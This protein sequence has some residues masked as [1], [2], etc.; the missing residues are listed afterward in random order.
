MAFVAG[1]VYAHMNGEANKAV[2]KDHMAT[3]EAK[4]LE[5]GTLDMT[6]ESAVDSHNKAETKGFV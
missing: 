5:A 3:F 4:C 6:A 1:K 2:S